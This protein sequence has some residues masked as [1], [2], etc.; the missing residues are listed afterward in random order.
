LGKFQQPQSHLS[1]LELHSSLRE[2]RNISINCKNLGQH[3]KSTF[4]KRQIAPL[5]FG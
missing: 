5:K 4:N 3:T 1:K 2:I